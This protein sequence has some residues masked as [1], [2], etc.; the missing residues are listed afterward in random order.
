MVQIKVNIAN[1]ANYGRQ[2]DLSAIKYIN[3]HYTGN[4]GDSDENNGKYFAD[5]IVKASA[6]YFV[7]DDSITQSVPDN[8]IAY[9]VGGKKY[10]NGGGRLY[11]TVNNS[12]SINI[13]LCDT[14]KN[15]VVVPTQKT[16]NNAI[17]LTQ[18]LMKKYNIPAHRVIR[19]FDV[20]GKEC[21]RY[22]VS[23]A[24]WKSY[25]WD[26]LGSVRETSGQDTN[27][28]KEP[29]LPV[30]SKAVAKEKGLLNFESQGESV[31]W[32]QWELE[33]VAP[34]Y[35][36][37]LELHGGIDGKC[38]SNTTALLELF[39]STYGLRSVDKICGKETRAALKAN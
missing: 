22:W 4:D 1:R 23:D 34:A 14:V 19:H 39:Q 18:M 8:Y 5:K 10:N 15:G 24:S 31:K 6:H 28:Y 37:F 21:P 25:F 7:D 12:N 35:K 38:G 2:R 16:I 13:E 30:T 17:E 32:L 9:S 3:I 29:F 36:D 27:P 20:N 11:G 26:K 33:Q